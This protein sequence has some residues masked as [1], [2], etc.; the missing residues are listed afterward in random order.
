MFFSPKELEEKLL[1][2]ESQYKN[3]IGYL[4]IELSRKPCEKYKKTEEISSKNTY[5]PNA[6]LL[7]EKDYK[8]YKDREFT[9][10]DKKKSV[11]EKPEKD[12]QEIKSEIEKFEKKVVRD[13]ERFNTFR[14]NE[15]VGG[16]SRHFIDKFKRVIDKLENRLEKMS[17]DI[18]VNNNSYELYDK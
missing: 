3:E 4:K 8:D 1:M 9:Q 18:K 15:E 7:S 12:L 14:S 5:N 17:S 6:S 11:K 10:S 2:T 16:D 13:S